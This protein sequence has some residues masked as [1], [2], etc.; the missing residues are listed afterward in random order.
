MARVFEVVETTVR[1]WRVALSDEYVER[2]RAVEGRPWP[3]DDELT[4]CAADLINDP[5]PLDTTV[6]LISTET[7][8]ESVE[9]TEEAEHAPD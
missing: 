9:L 3:G 5:C 1:R 8:G 4:T 6:E 7:T 2:C